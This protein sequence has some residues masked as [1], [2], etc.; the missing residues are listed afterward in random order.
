[1]DAMLSFPLLTAH[2]AA[3]GGV[4]A[5]SARASSSA[6]FSGP[7]MLEAGRLLPGDSAQVTRRPLAAAV[8]LELALLGV[9]LIVRSAEAALCRMDSFCELT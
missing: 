5:L 1:M 7:A 6:I 2:S 8:A 4:S 9:G 3:R